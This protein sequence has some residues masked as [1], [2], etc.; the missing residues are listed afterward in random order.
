MERFKSACWIPSSLQRWERAHASAESPAPLERN[1]AASYRAVLPALLLLAC[2]DAI[3]PARSRV[4]SLSLDQPTGVVSLFGTT[5]VGIHIRDRDGALIAAPA[6][7]QWTS[8]APAIATVSE[9]GV[10]SGEVLGG[11]VAIIASLEGLADTTIFTVVP[12]RVEVTSSHSALDIGGTAQLAGTPVDARGAA[13]PGLNVTWSVPTQGLAPIGVVT[14][15]GAFTAHQAGFARIRASAAGRTTEFTLGVRSPYDGEWQGERTNGNPVGL[16]IVYGTVVSFRLP[17][18]PIQ[19][20]TTIVAQ[21][22]PNE[23]IVD[24]RAVFTIPTRAGAQPLRAEIAVV[25]ADS[26]NG[27][28]G[29]M[30]F[31]LLPCDDGTVRSGLTI[32]PGGP[33]HALKQ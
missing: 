3:T 31:V 32:V 18:V 21:G 13:I 16:T 14:D 22:A 10:V 24:G 15:G 11:P 30:G 8:T 4:A 33:F 23:L 12:D 6:P 19:L 25:T 17:A 29:E 28:T 2:S 5:K 26:L 20:C 1:A 27:V 9:D 7:V